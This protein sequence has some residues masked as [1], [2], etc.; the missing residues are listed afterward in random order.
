LHG[1]EGFEKRAELE[2]QEH[3]SEGPVA[4]IYKHAN[5]KLLKVTLD[6]TG[7]IL[8]IY[9]ELWIITR[10]L[11]HSLSSKPPQNQKERCGI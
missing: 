10:G 5:L 9:G 7:I 3:E 1:F 8:R 11:E 6:R 4:Y 2:A